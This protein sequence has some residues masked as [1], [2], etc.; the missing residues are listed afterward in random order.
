MEAITRIIVA[1]QQSIR[2]LTGI[3]I[4]EIMRMPLFL[5]KKVTLT[6]FLPEDCKRV[7]DIALEVAERGII[8]GD[9]LFCWQPYYLD[10]T[11]LPYKMVEFI[12]E[13]L[14]LKRLDKIIFFLSQKPDCERYYTIRHGADI[15]G[16]AA[17][18]NGWIDFECESTFPA[19]ELAFIHPDFRDKE[20]AKRIIS[21]HFEEYCRKSN[22]Y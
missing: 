18:W 15:I 22:E 21:G 6:E 17:F 13:N 2:Y 3:I 20:H 5:S 12:G 8:Y 10:E 14:K 9:N 16:F 1:E 4:N 7:E 11:V 19:I